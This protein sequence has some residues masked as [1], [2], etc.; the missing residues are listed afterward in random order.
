[1]KLPYVV[2]LAFHIE[3]L[4][5]RRVE[6]R[7]TGLRPNVELNGILHMARIVSRELETDC[8]V[9]QDTI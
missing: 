6:A 7:S 5:E 2:A 3:L 8:D 4:R 1:M 9:V